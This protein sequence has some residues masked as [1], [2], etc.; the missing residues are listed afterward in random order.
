M[1]IDTLFNNPDDWFTHSETLT[2]SSLEDRLT[3][4]LETFRHPSFTPDFAADAGVG[5]VLI[6]IMGDLESEKR[7][8]ELIELQQTISTLQPEFYAKEFVYINDTLLA[9]ALFTNNEALAKDLFAPFV[10]DPTRDID[11]YLPLLRLIVLYGKGEW[12]YDIVLKNYQTI[13]HTDGFMG[14]PHSDL[15]V[16]TWHQI[17]ELAYKKSKETGIFDLDAWLI[18]S[19]KFDFGALDTESQERLLQLFT[20]PVPDKATLITQFQQD[21][22]SLL[23][24]L[25]PY[26]MRDNYDNKGIP[27]I[28]SGTIWDLM[29]DYW[30]KGS[31][32]KASFNLT[33][34][35]FDKYCGGLAGF[36]GQYYCN[37]VASIY[38]AY[39]VYDFL[40]R[41]GL[42]DDTL[43]KNALTGIRF[44]HQ[45]VN[46]SGNRVWRNGFPKYWAKPDAM[47]DI[48]YA[49][50]NQVIDASFA[51]VEVIERKKET[52]DDLVRK[53]VEAAKSSPL[54]KPK[55]ISKPKPIATTPKVG[56]NEPCPCGSGKKYK[57]CCGK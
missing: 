4:L 33:T 6:T 55:P 8:D 22:H 12:V 51:H 35:S 46:R 49:I 54:L 37:A 57:H 45:S 15:A 18:E 13:K 40:H 10:E 27:F 17:S 47:T 5:D 31:G 16:Y 29:M 32:K 34:T 25:S 38:G 43:Y 21:S 53:M 52:T 56:R 41:I 48:E 42:I 30:F 2:E 3:F 44:C 11:V 28:I 24:S 50:N 39:H 1:E 26:F 19:A 14:E 9:Y 7:F 23:R 20:Q 36:F